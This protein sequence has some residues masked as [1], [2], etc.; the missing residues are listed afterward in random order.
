MPPT[1]SRWPRLSDAWWV[2]ALACAAVVLFPVGL[3]VRLRCSLGRCGN[4]VVQH[5]F[6][7]DSVGGLP[8]LFTTGLFA[9]VCGLAWWAVRQ[10]SGGPRT[11][12]TAVSAIGAVLAL[13]KRVSAHSVA[14]SSAPVATLLVSVLLTVVALVA[15]TV[16]GRRWSVPAA[17]PVVIAFAVYAT[18]ALGIE[19]IAAAALAAQSH[20]GSLTAAT[21]TFIEEFG[22]AATALLLV[23]TVRWHL[24]AR[25][26]GGARAE[27]VLQDSGSAS[28]APEAGDA[29]QSVRQQ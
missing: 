19:A 25:S 24:P 6:D 4:A 20:V 1:P 28:N 9:A 17:R 26:E 11:W 16:G 21:T 5:L 7:L 22:E 23:V 13:A 8:R 27:R 12:W 14:K 2:Y 10:C 3:V 18:A 29:G 15:L